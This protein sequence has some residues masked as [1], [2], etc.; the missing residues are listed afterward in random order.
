M[1]TES[2][3]KIN[4]RVASLAR[5]LRPIIVWL[6]DL[7]SSCKQLQAIEYTIKVREIPTVCK[8]IY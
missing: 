1:N 6:E 3:K 5:H 2:E 7:H 8:S 4:R